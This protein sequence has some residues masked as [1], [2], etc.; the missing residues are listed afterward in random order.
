M[1]TRFVTEEEDLSELPVLYVT[2]RRLVRRLTG[3]TDISA[4]Y[5]TV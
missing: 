2:V 4:L 1:Y 3:L 5:A